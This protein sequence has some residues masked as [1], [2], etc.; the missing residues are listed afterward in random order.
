MKQFEIN[1]FARP[2]GSLNT[3]FSKLHLLTMI[4]QNEDEVVKMVY[5]KFELV[6]RTDIQ[7]VRVLW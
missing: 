1:L 4:A 7:E 5:D 6:Q 3:V 2:K